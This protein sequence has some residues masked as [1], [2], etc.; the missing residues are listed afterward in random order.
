MYISKCI[1]IT[2]QTYANSVKSICWLNESG[3]KPAFILPANYWGGAGRGRQ[4]ETDKHTVVN[5]QVQVQVQVQ[6]LVHLEAV[7]VSAFMI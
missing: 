4:W 1:I 6:V 2:I 5:L 3:Q 7:D